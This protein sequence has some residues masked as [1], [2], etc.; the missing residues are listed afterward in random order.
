MVSPATAG[1]GLLH[2]WYDGGKSIVPLD[3]TTPD[4]AD[5]YRRLAAS[6]DL[7]IEN[8]AP[9]RLSSLGLDHADMVAT[10]P[11]LVQVS[12][13]PFG[14]NGPWA[15]W[16][17]TDLVA[18]ALGGVLSVSG[19]AE[20]AINPWGRQSQHFGAYTAAICGL[21]AVRAAHETG[22]GQLV[23]VSLH[24]V[25]ASSIEQ[26]WFEYH[27]DDVLPLAKIAPRQGSLHWL[28]AYVVSRCKT[29]WCMISPTPAAGPLLEWM[30]E[31]G[32]E[33]APEL[34]KTDSADLLVHLDSVMDATR[35]FALT[36]DAGPLFLEAQSR[37]VAFGEVQSVAQVAT[38]PQF[39]FR[40]FIHEI[41]GTD[42]KRPGHPVVYRGTP[43]DGPKSPLAGDIGDIL[44]EWGAG[45]SATDA[46]TTEGPTSQACSYGPYRMRSSARLL[47]VGSMWTPRSTDAISAQSCT[48]SR[49]ASTRST[50]RASTAPNC[51]ATSPSGP[52]P[53]ASS[54]AGRWPRPPESSS[55][56]CC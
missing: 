9:G 20:H 43:L 47:C 41:A 45:S 33:G 27:Y 22:H 10:N 51:L 7:I 24:E 55:S 48:I 6:A 26:L 42:V 5:A 18:S 11:R 1:A 34:A 56:S 46:A 37:H 30:V 53:S 38:N 49:S 36:K 19:T 35:R 23:D 3:L 25:I 8:E 17:S 13:T 54:K 40:G 12:L 16:Q 15:H 28:R 31:E 39:E 29:G 52:R 14:R 50:C 21:A 44:S 2:W 32:V 4:G